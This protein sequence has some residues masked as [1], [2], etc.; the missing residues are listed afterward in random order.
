M[1]RFSTARGRGLVAPLTLVL[2]KCQVYGGKQS[3]KGGGRNG[4]GGGGGRLTEK[5]PSEQTS[6]A[7]F[8]M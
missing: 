1:L 6:L 3:R 8:Y 7:P 5:A 4:G 2:S